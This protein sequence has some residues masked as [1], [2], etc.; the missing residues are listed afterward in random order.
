[1]LKKVLPGSGARLTSWMDFSS[2]LILFPPFGMCDPPHESNPRGWRG[3][4]S[5][6]GFE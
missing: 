4:M 1:M 6:K 2:L 3:G 5:G